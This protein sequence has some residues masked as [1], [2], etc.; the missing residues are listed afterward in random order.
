MYSIY[1]RQIGIPYLVKQS[2][3]PARIQAAMIGLHC[4]NYIPGRFFF[5]LLQRSGQICNDKLT[6]QRD[7]K[8]WKIAGEVILLR[9]ETK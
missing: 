3:H 2:G 9:K 1:L 5:A 6:F 7:I 4:F 8:I